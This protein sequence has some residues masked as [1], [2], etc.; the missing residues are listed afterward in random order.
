MK[1][2]NKKKEREKTVTLTNDEWGVL[3]DYLLKGMEYTERQA[4]AHAEL[5]KIRVGD[6]SIKYENAA[7]KEQ[8]WRGINK[9]LEE[10]RTKIDKA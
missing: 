3:T 2:L 8:Y 9:Q 10:I 6:G 5:A 4:N 7:S 1:E